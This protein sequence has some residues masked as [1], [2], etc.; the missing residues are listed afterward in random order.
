MAIIE[1][2]VLSNLLVHYIILIVLAGS[3]TLEFFRRKDKRGIKIYY[4]VISGISIFMIIES[5]RYLVTG[6]NPVLFFLNPGLAVIIGFMIFFNSIRNKE[7]DKKNSFLIFMYTWLIA[8]NE[9]FKILNMGEIYGLL[10]SL[11]TGIA[12]YLL[13]FVIINFLINTSKEVGVKKFAETRKK[14]M[15]IFFV[16]GLILFFV[17]LE[18]FILS[19]IGVI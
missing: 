4:F 8:L 14:E 1:G 13:F 2:L 10:S 7:A 9:I 3:L 5:L 18:L 12:T 19:A 6:I 11:V 15:E 17:N 16:V